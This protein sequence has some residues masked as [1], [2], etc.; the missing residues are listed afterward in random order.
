MQNFIDTHHDA[1]AI[2]DWNCIDAIELSSKPTLVER[3]AV[4]CQT[5]AGEL[6]FS[7]H[8]QGVRLISAQTRPQDY[9]LLMALP[10]INTVSLTQDENFT[11]VTASNASSADACVCLRIQHQPFSFEVTDLQ[12]KHYLRSPRDGHFVRKHRVPPLAKTDQGWWVS[13]DLK[14][15]EPVYGLGEKW[16]ALNKRGQLLRSYNSDA[17]GVNAEISYKNIPFCWSPEGWGMLCHTPA[18]VTHAVGHA[19]WSQRT[20]TALIE[21]AFLD[22]FFF[23]SQEQNKGEDIV[24]QLTDL[25]GRAPVPPQF[26][27]GVI[28]SKAYYKDADELLAV[29]REVRAREMPCDVITID[30]RAWQDTRTRFAFEWDASRYPDPA[31]VMNELKELNFKVCVWEYPLISVEHDWFEMFSKNGWLLTDKRTGEAYQYDWDQQ[32]FGDV[33]TGTAALRHCGFYAS[34]GIC[35]LARC[36]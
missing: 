21:D 5:T 4:S 32:A 23:T 7:L 26:S 15:S 22:V 14:S 36:A 24:R 18:P 30:G 9:E 12:G 6:R 3:S 2:P 1:I 29:A 17:L 13:L 27:G 33:L 34:G 10:E 35:V 19:A 25:T 20:Y 31:V 8:D 28:L 11:V 16:G